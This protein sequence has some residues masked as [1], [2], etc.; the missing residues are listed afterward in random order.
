MEAVVVGAEG[1]SEGEDVE[2]AV[3][4]GGGGSCGCIRAG[5]SWRRRWWQLRVHVQVEEAVAN[6][7]PKSALVEADGMSLKLNTKAT[8]K[9]CTK[10]LLIRT[11]DVVAAALIPIS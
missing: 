5:C 8:E 3:V 1:A 10:S 6:V 2:V 4:A 9:Y 7:K 11:R